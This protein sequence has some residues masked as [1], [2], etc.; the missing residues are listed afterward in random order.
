MN[1]L[2]YNDLA[3]VD[4]IL[5]RPEDLRDEVA[6]YVQLI[7]KNAKFPPRTLL[8]LGCGAGGYDMHLKRDFTI[9]GI[10]LCGGMLAIARERNPEVTYRQADMR[11]FDL[12]RQFD[13]VIIPD[14]IDYMATQADLQAAIERA[15]THLKSGGVLLI[16]AKSAEIFQNN[17]FCY[18]GSADETEVTLFENNYIL[19]SGNQYE[20][21]LVYLI[22]KAG[23]LSV[24]HETH[25]LGLFARSLRMTLLQN[26]GLAVQVVPLA[27]LYDAALMGEDGNYPMEIFVGVKG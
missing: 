11:L 3:W 27:G 17:N 9:T 21:T 16:T 13:A 19:P 24:F 14:S 2:S 10:D 25:R 4:T 7:R 20:A 6:P 5:A 22:R 23:K 8:H 26:A 15:C 18:T 1:W 12:G